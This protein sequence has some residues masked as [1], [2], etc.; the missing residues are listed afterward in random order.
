MEPRTMLRRVFA[1]QHMALVFRLLTCDRLYICLA[2]Q[3]LIFSS[4]LPWCLGNE[5]SFGVIASLC[6]KNIL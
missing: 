2:S 4:S 5:N 3:W 1:Y 6:Y